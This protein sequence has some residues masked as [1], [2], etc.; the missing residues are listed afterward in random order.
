MM[1]TLIFK[2]LTKIIGDLIHL[3]GCYMCNRYVAQFL[4]LLV[5]PSMK[6]ANI[7]SQNHKNLR[8]GTKL[9][10]RAEN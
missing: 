9:L 2:Y 3:I 1:V 5:I 7:K 4:I 6:E 8:T 10:Q